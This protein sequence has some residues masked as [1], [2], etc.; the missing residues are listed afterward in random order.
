MQTFTGLQYLQ[1]DIASHFGL[2]KLDWDQ[3]IAWAEENEEQLEDLLSRAE[4]PAMYF[5]AVQAYRKTQKGQPTGYAIS[6][7]AASSGL[8]LLAVLTGCEASARLCGVVSTGHREDAYT[9]IYKAMCAEIGDAARIDRKDTKVAIM[10]SLYSSTAEPRRVFGEGELLRIFY[11][12]MEAMAPG[13]WALNQALRELWQPDALSH[14]WVL[15]D[16]FHAHIKVMK[17]VTRYVQFQ[18]TPVPVTLQVNEGTREGRALGPNVIHSVDGMIVREMHRRCSYDPAMLERLIVLLG[19]QSRYEGTCKTRPQD[20]LVARLWELYQASGFLSAR[21][22]DLLDEK[23]IGLVD[24][25]LIKKLVLGLPAKPFP[26]ISIHDCFRAHPNYGND[27][28]NQYRTILAEIADSTLLT[29]I[30]SQIVGRYLP[31]SKLGEIGNL[32]R[33]SDYA[34]C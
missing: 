6:L 2:D 17:S 21:I 4:T 19:N 30:A 33:Q 25:E 22:L 12:T 26:V 28:R 24:P 34:I 16:N 1:I 27:L 31:A 14:D 32:V 20:K 7:D 15:P 29:F 18:N 3:R 10:T 23:N 13:A 11:Q 5:A 8:Q 9:V